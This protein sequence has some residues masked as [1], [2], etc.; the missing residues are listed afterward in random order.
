MTTL[1]SNDGRVKITTLENGVRVASYAG[2]H[3]VRAHVGVGLRAGP[4]HETDSTWGLSHIVEHMVFRGTEQFADAHAVSL[5]ADAFGGDLNASTWRDR[6]LFETRVDS[7]AVDRAIALLGDMWRRPRLEGLETEREV[8]REEF[9]EAL[10]DDGQMTDADTV[11][12]AN[13]FPDAAIGRSIEGTLE[14]L[15]QVT[16]RDVEAH[17]R[18]LLAGENLIVVGA[19]A[20]AH[21]TLVAAAMTTFGDLDRG[22]PPALGTPGPGRRKQVREVRTDQ[23]Q[24]TLRLSFRLPADAELGAREIEFKRYTAMLERILDDGPATR[25]QEIVDREGLAYEVWADVDGYP[26]GAI[27]DFGAQVAHDR[28]GVVVERLVREVARL[29]RE[30]V[31]EAE[32][33]RTKKRVRRDY[34][35]LR[36]DPETCCDAL[37]RSALRGQLFDPQTRV[38]GLDAVSADAL[39]HHAAE[40]FTFARVQ[41]T[42][43]GRP[44]RAAVAAATKALERLQ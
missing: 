40:I 11:A 6:M 22:A 12:M 44:T 31:S 16:R 38:A 39:Q 33:E 24:T 30:P 23:S 17:W 26:E 2:P 13:A 10:D 42:L 14:A 43:V 21:E 4:R 1:R 15:D 3:L 28:V 19:G 37:F 7:D 29:K 20:I 41:L 8:L 34:E 25:L 36:D 32:L 5:E 18:A 27:F 9:L 35:D